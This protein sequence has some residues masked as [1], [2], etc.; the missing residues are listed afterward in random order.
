MKYPVVNKYSLRER[1]HYFE[2][3]TNG[4]Q[5]FFLK[6]IKQQ[7]DNGLSILITLNCSINIILE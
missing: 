4:L 7:I 5:I 1:F 2:Y 6:I 3:K